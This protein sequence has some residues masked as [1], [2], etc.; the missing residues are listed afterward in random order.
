MRPP[1]LLLLVLFIIAVAVAHHTFISVSAPPPGSKRAEP[2]F[3]EPLKLEYRMM[4][5]KR[6]DS[7]PRRD[8]PG[9]EYV[10]PL[11]VG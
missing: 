11:P 5:I 8:V 3:P 6:L 1:M 2:V 9:R 4:Q 10:P 7:P